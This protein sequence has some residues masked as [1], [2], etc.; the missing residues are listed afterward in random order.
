MQCKESFDRQYCPDDGELGDF[1]KGL[2]IEQQ[3]D[4]DKQ[5]EKATSV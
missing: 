5:L 4:S 3:L 1:L 2:T